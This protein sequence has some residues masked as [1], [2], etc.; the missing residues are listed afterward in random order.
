MIVY[1]KNKPIE[2]EAYCQPEDL[3]E[4]TSKFD[5]IQYKVFVDYCH[6]KKIKFKINEN[7]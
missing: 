7:T 2:V 5:R 3:K 4:L 1:F 6:T